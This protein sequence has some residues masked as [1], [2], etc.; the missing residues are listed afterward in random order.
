MLRSHLRQ[1]M[2][3]SEI[4]ASR[5]LLVEG[6]SDKR[7]LRCMLGYLGIG[8]QIEI[9]SYRGKNNI[10]HALRL[11]RESAV[12]S[13]GLV[14]SVGL[15]RDADHKGCGSARQS[16]L[17]ALYR[18]GLT[19][20]QND[21]RPLVTGLQ[22]S[23]HVICGSDGCGRLEEMILEAVSG[24]PIMKQIDR[25]VTSLA[26]ASRCE[27][28]MGKTRLSLYLNNQLFDRREAIYAGLNFSHPVYDDLK[29]FLL[30][31]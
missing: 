2:I 20:S 31:L 23:T 29:G 7:F 28:D 15:T 1:R 19:R 10:G 9:K 26:R 27:L 17:G 11:L 14:E 30:D 8:R 13:R 4:L 3:G 6:E 24:Y 18:A 12:F 16:L 25:Q 21:V 22:I 5:L